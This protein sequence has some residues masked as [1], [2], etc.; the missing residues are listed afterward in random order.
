LDVNTE[1]QTTKR[2]PGSLSEWFASLTPRLDP[3]TFSSEELE[4]MK[5]DL[6]AML[7]PVEDG[8]LKVTQNSD[9]EDASFRFEPVALQDTKEGRAE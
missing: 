5:H 2:I 8:K 4:R 7:E 3:S 9:A 6:E 1:E